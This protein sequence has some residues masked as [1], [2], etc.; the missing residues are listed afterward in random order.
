MYK[1]FPGSTSGQMTYDNCQI[2]LSKRIEKSINN[3]NEKK[4]MLDRNWKLTK[5]KY[6]ALTV[7]NS[8]RLN[9]MTKNKILLQMNCVGAM[10]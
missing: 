2:F 7:F 4:E 1:L 10:L 9:P 3:M 5:Y 8:S 6:R